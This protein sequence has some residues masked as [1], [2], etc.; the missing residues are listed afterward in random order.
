MP[1]L[2]SHNPC[3][4]VLGCKLTVGWV[5]NSMRS[6]EVQHNRD[7]T[8]WEV[9]L[10]QGLRQK[11]LTREITQDVIAEPRFG[12]PLASPPAAEIRSVIGHFD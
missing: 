2:Q 4:S 1:V 11:A 3:V 5:E 9:S 10:M 8:G 12:T 7:L 6:T